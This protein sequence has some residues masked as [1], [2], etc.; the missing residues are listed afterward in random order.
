[1]GFWAGFAQARKE[2]KDQMYR[3][4]ERVAEQEWQLGRDKASRQHEIDMFQKKLG[5]ERENAMINAWLASAT[6]GGTGASKSK[7]SS[8]DHSKHLAYIQG[9]LKGTEG[10][11][12]ILRL[13]KQDPTFAADWYNMALSQEKEIGAGNLSGQFLVDNTT[14]YT[15]DDGDDEWIMP[16]LQ[17]LID[18]TDFSNPVD[19]ATQMRSLQKPATSGSAFDFS[20][21][22]SG[23]VRKRQEETFDTLL[24]QAAEN[25]YQR[26][27]N[28]EDLTPEQERRKES[29]NGALTNLQSDDKGTKTIARGYLSR[30]FGGTVAS[31]MDEQEDPAF[32][33]WRDNPAL[34]YTIPRSTEELV[35]AYRNGETVILTQEMK[36]MYPDVFEGRDV[37]EN[38]EADL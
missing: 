18:E 5:A 10:G 28:L 4:S 3:T 22:V 37:G 19:V 9:I 27:L 36:D 29:I 20:P 30:E 7:G 14:V 16:D 8:S 15:N 32:S 26:L 13:A 6:S 25:E 33:Q 35:E 23:D 11:E 34:R 24:V 38:V 17:E 31:L 2:H 1:M 21:P 12:E